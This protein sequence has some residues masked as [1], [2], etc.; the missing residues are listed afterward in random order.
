MAL[1]IPYDGVHPEVPDSAFVAPNA[2]L[3]GKVTLGERSSV[4]YG[5]VLRGDMDAIIVGDD[6]NLQDNVTVHCD[7]GKPT[8]LGD[9]VG[10]GHGAILHGC[11][12]EDGSLIGMGAIVLN[13][14]VVG[15][16][17]L[18]AAGAVVRE[19][20]VVPPGTLVAGVPAKVL[21]E[22]T[23]GEIERV[24]RNS[25]AYVELGSKHRELNAE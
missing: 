22:L 16:G 4:F 1:T 25:V 5:A 14:A 9:R 8:I 21:R 2:T 13:D 3:I 15:A 20:F 18:V 17:S 10:V 12:I 24:A 23:E 11:R 7:G 19:G 6:S